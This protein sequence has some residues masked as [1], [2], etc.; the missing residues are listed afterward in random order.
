MPQKLIIVNVLY[1]PM[2]TVC[3]SGEVERLEIQVE[4]LNPKSESIDIFS[5]A[6]GPEDL[7]TYL[8]CVD[9]KCIRVNWN[10]T[11]SA[12]SYNIIFYQ[13]YYRKL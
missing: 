11:K 10:L 9:G 3:I 6:T 8:D 13:L 4:E 1:I 12:Q 5:I 7:Q 2:P